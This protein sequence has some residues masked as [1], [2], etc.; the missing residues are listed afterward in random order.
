MPTWLATFIKRSTIRETI[1]DTHQGEPPAGEGNLQLQDFLMI[2]TTDG[3]KDEYEIVA[4]LEDEDGS[5]YAI[6]YSEKSDQ[7]IV[8]DGSGTILDNDELAQEILDD[9]IVFAQESA[10]ED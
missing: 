1:I 4:L 7:F 8:T 6:A 9:Y 10:G 5:G 3:R 2:E